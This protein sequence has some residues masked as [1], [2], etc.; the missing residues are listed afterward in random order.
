[1]SSKRPASQR[2]LIALLSIVLALGLVPV[3]STPAVAASYAAPSGLRALSTSRDALSLSWG[4]VTGAPRY[5]IQY[6]TSSSMKSAKY[7]N[8]DSTRYSLRGLKSNTTYYVKVRV[9]SKAGDNLSSYSKAFKVKTRTKGSYRRLAPVN[10]KST[11][12]TSKSIKL[13][14]SPS[15]K[16]IRYRIAYSTNSKFSKPVYRRYTDPR[17]SLTGLKAN[18]TYYVKVRVITTKGGSLSAYSPAVK[19]TTAKAAVGAPTSPTPSG[20]AP[21]GLK[22]ERLAQTAVA[23][24]W[25]P[26]KGAAAYRVEAATSADFS[27][28]IAQRFTGTAGELNGLTK[29][30]SYHFRIVVATSKG[31]PAGQYSAPITGKTPTEE[32]DRYLTPTG[33]T[34]T[35]QVATRIGLTWNSR[36]SGM[37]YQVRYAT[38]S[39]WQDVKTVTTEATS[40][41]LSGL[42]ESAKYYLQVRVV[43][44]S[45]SAQSRFGPSPA[46][47]ESTTTE[48]D[49]LT[50]ASYNVKCANCYSGLAEEGTWYERREAVTNTIL[51]QAPDVIGIQEASQGW[52]KDSK[53]KAISLA[54]FEDLEDRLGSPYKV[55]NSHRNN[56]VKSST[57]SNCVYK[58]QGA[59]Q[60]T[61][62]FYNSKTVKLVKQGSRRLSEVK[63]SANDRYVAWAVFEDLKTSKRF[64]FADTHLEPQDSAHQLRITQA[65]ELLEAV[66]ENNPDN[67]PAFIVGDLNSSK[68]STPSNGPYD[69]V[70]AA[71]FVD[72]L[73]NYYKSKD[74]QVRNPTV[75]RRIRTNYSSYNGFKRRPPS[76]SD[77]NAA[78]IDY[79]FTSP[80]TR[81]LEWETYLSLDSAGNF[82]GRIPSDHNLIRATV[83]LPTSNN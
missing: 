45:G 12:V 26:V 2:W 61:R 31:D 43:S 70:L 75:E 25:K 60:G 6:S 21:D 47:T 52:L 53:G 36:G 5:R 8:T 67:L 23:L 44:S 57:P 80:G 20:P 33:L 22:L 64:M 49:G 72:P 34:V 37:R 32:A 35:G 48:L 29:G 56:C 28:P 1:M 76:T 46:V 73:G 10:L 79:I 42:R 50:I 30:T 41:T 51:M 27:K 7:A 74:K 19:V 58:D 39:K 15:G 62:I 54:Q 38:D 55:T 65:K 13:T 68:R 4:A 11:E 71:G 40:V 82:A 24:S 17:A 66:Q 63:A 81:V 69:E 14:W 9:I 59:S 3:W 18:T 77:L 83:V 78:N 16:G